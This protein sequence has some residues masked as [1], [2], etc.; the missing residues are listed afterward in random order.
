MRADA[1]TSLFLTNHDH[2]SRTGDGEVR[3]ADDLG[4]NLALE[5]QAA[6]MLLTTPGKPFV[7]QGE[8]LGYWGNSKNR[9]DEYLRAPI[10]WDA[11]AKDCAKNGVNGK[12]DNAMLTGSI[13]VETQSKDAGSLLTVY[14][15]FGTLRNTYPALAEG[16]MTAGPSTGDKTVAAWYMTAGSQKMLVVHNVSSSSK[17][18]TLS[19][20]LSKPVALLGSGQTDGNKLIL[21]ANS[22]VVFEL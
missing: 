10:V 5:K 6:A 21:G 3:A 1:V 15:T 22:S 2:S 16:T 14:K 17:T 9:G 20:S 4:K 13:S 19:D 18:V 7:Y 8:E 11:A 12:V